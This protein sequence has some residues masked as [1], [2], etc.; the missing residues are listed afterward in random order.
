MT[1][2][3]TEAVGGPCEKD[4]VTTP[5]ISACAR[6]GTASVLVAM[7]HDKKFRRLIAL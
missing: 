6:P 7:R 3:S 5:S 4:G 2:C 1:P